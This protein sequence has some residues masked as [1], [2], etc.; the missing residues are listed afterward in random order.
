MRSGLQKLARLG[1]NRTVGGAKLAISRPVGLCLAL[2]LFVSVP[3]SSASA[4]E[5]F[6]FSFSR[7]GIERVAETRP[8]DDIPNPVSYDVSVRAGGSDITE[9]LE[10]ASILFEKK[11]TP[12]SGSTGL[13]VRA[14]NDHKRLIAA[15]Y[16]QG[17]YGGT[18]DIK[19]NG[20]RYDQIGVDEDLAANAPAKVTIDVDPGEIFR[21]SEPKAVN[22][23]GSTIALRDFGVKAGKP[24][25]SQLVLD[26]ED[27]IV[28]DY[29]QQGYPLARIAERSLEADHDRTQLDVAL[30]V[31]RGPRARL[32]RVQVSGTNAVDAA[33]VAKQADV[34]EGDV[35]SP[36]AIAKSARNLRALGVFDS[37]IVKTG[38]EVLP[39]GTIPVEIEV[40]ERRFRTIGAGVTV[41]NLDGLGVEGYWT[42]RN[43]FGRAESLRVEGSISHIGQRPIDEID[44]NAAII[45]AKP[46][47]LGPASVFD[48]KLALEA[49]NPDAF[50]KRSV[51]GEIGISQQWTEQ[52]SGRAGF[53]AEYARIKDSKG[54]D[55]TLLFS[56]PLEL[57]Y[58][59][60]DSKLDPTE[61]FSLLLKAEPTVSS[62]GDVAYFKNSATITAYQALD[63]AKRFVLAGKLSAGSIV[64][65]SKSD[66]PADRRF[67]AGG[68]GSIRG[69]AFQAA[70]PRDVNNNP[71][72]GRSFATASLE[73]RV[74]VTEQM[75][76]A[77]FVDTGAAFDSL[78]PSAD[79]DW[80][81]GV[82]AGVR[83]LT[84]IGP[85]RLDVAVP[86]KTIKNEPKYG[87][88]LGLG[89]AF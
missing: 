21:F 72:G 10:A 63:K 34:P 60:R 73:A 32:G 75:G 58:D 35:Y 71:S 88:Y 80:Y 12:V 39:D 53:K 50:E 38:D 69:Y 82:G 40:T 7:S 1:V 33:F 2:G 74:K 15:L 24:A 76:L 4:F 56:L 5:L 6:G 77:A 54:M 57:T 19:I 78:L 43:L 68:G 26:A 49:S 70:G 86:L 47:V 11:D 46:G 18:V 52:L 23:D 45:F 29:R 17:R 51:S 20:Q 41:G 25:L 28:A 55:H 61:G 81:T 27:A 83:Y 36:E 31:D 22:D 59:E 14:R 66:I 89:Q 48:A 9:D 37:V 42:H 79:G 87:V 30:Q 3:L 16:R 64:G 65:A 85:L 8:T 84:P 44:Y 67:Y 13:L 62:N